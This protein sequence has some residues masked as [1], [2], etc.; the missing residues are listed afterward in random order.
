MKRGVA[1]AK[2]NLA[3]VV[4]PR[5]DNGKHEVATVYQR[6]TLADAIEVRRAE[7]THVSGF[8]DDSLVA[9][10]WQKVFEAKALEVLKSRL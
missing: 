4:G 6:I 1:A 9:P 7:R 8:A 5:R 2:I 3:L 10:E